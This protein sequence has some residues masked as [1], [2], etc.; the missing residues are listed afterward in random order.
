MRFAQ[1]HAIIILSILLG[2]ALFLA[3]IAFLTSTKNNTIQKQTQAEESE[4]KE[5]EQSIG[6]QITTSPPGTH[7]A[8]Q[9]DSVE[10]QIV[11][12][13]DTQLRIGKTSLNT[14]SAT[15]IET[16][17]I[18]MQGAEGISG[19]EIYLD[20]ENGT[21]TAIPDGITTNTGV[22]DQFSTIAQDVSSDGKKAVSAYATI[23]TAD[24]D[25]PQEVTFTVQVQPETGQTDISQNISINTS[26]SIATG[27]SI[28]YTIV[29]E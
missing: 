2:V 10:T 17:Q 5:M 29:E 4:P 8:G 15:G 19:F 21:F 25:L 3:G 26:K 18:T 22:E 7:A 11:D 23:L 6:E 13:T 20:I 9:T 1:N 14:D 12:Q 16:V 27:P 24:E 28:E